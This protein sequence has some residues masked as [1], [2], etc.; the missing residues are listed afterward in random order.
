MNAIDIVKKKRKEKKYTQSDIADILGIK[1]ST[2]SEIENKRIQ[3]KADDLIKIC[4]FLNISFNEFLG[5]E[6]KSIILTPL[7][8]ET[9]KSL[10]KKIQ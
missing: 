3:L 5:E 6:N 8:I 7:E 1:R 2:Y 9:I 10:C 4:C